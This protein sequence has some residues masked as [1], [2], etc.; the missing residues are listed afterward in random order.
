M[1]GAGM[2]LAGVGPTML[3]AQ[4]G[5]WAPNSWYSLIGAVA[6]TVAYSVA[7]AVA[8][9]Y[10]ADKVSTDR[11]PDQAA[12][13][14]CMPPETTKTHPDE[15]PGKQS[16]PPSELP[17]TVFEDLS[18]LK[19]FNYTQ[20]AT[21]FGTV[22]IIAAVVFE[23]IFPFNEEMST[24]NHG[25]VQYADGWPPIVAGFAV[26]L[27]QIPLRLI[28]GDGQGGSTS[29]HSWV[30]TVTLGKI[31]GTEHLVMNEWGMWWQTVYVWFG[32]FGGALVSAATYGELALSED[33][34]TYSGSN[35]NPYADFYLRY[36]CSQYGDVFWEDS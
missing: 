2:A 19:N 20:L 10:F 9:T 26:G 25:S 15:S 35:P 34:V 14:S 6:G 27:G 31:P 18:I 13:S 17:L 4:I 1:L 5:S 7:N 21:A 12:S 36:V 32:T 30:A 24:Y 29:I 16:T 8:I 33:E 22:L 28:T 11:L 23:V 3:P